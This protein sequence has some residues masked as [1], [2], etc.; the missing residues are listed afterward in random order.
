VIS[1]GIKQIGLR[2]PALVPT[3]TDLTG[4][5]YTFVWETTYPNLAA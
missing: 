5:Y 2:E 4:P 3:L 1:R